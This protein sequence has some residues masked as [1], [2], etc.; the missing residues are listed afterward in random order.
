M[1][2]EARRA[3]WIDPT[4]GMA[5][6]MFAAALIGLGVPERTMV[7]AMKAAGEE[8]GLVDIHAHL[9]F[10]PDGTPGYR[11]HVTVAEERE[12]LAL[13]DAPVYLDHALTR[14]GVKGAYADFARRA[15]A[16]LCEAERRVH[17]VE[18]TAVPMARTVS[19]PVIGTAHTP[20]QR[21]APYQ[22]VPGDAIDG[23][24]Y[25]ELDPQYAAGLSGLETFTHVFV[26]SYLD[27]SLGYALKVRPPWRRSTERYGVFATRSPNRPSPIGLTRARVR[28]VEG[29]RVYTGPLDLFDGTPILDLKPFVRS[30]DSVG[31]ENIGNDGWL[32][33]SEHLELHRRGVPH[34]HPGQSYLHEAQDIVIDVT[35]AAWGLQWL[36]VDLSAVTCLAPVYVGGGTVMTSHGQLSIPAPATRFILERYHIPYTSGPVEAELLT[37]TGAAILAALNPIFVPRDEG[38]AGNTRVG[39][40]LGHHTFDRP[41]AL[42]LYR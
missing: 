5:G 1:V 31:T 14:A 39:A 7:R 23:A 20:Y 6:D 26:V 10:L 24:F 34:V 18:P 4:M 41:N 32:E 13:E 33:G 25:I 9:D 8:L 21:E 27:R 11:L 38:V 30:L 19:L 15:L 40:G 12:P 36:H 22:P 29:N 37:P 42:W 3:L 35:G 16:I 28:R 2:E 17:A